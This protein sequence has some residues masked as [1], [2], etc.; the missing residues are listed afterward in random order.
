MLAI[1]VHW[2]V[3]FVN[4]GLKAL[5]GAGVP[6]PTKKNEDWEVHEAIVAAGYK[7]CAVAVE[8]HSADGIRVRSKRL[9]A[10]SCQLD[11]NQCLF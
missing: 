1:H 7:H 11:P 6:Y 3:V 2:G 5:P 10:L 9:Q 4:D 8:V